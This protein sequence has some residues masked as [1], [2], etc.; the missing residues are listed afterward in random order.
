MI[1]LETVAYD[2]WE[3]CYRIANE[4]IELLVPL[5]IGIRIIHFGFVGEG[6]LFKTYP[7]YN[8]KAGGDDWLIYG[9][10]RLWLAPEDP[11]R[12]Y[13]PDNN[14]ITVENHDNF[15]R[16]IQPIETQTGIQKEIDIYMSDNSPHVKLVH[17]LRNMNLWAVEV[18]PWAL[19]V[20]NSNGTAIAPLPQR[21][22]HS[23]MMI[24]TSSL[25][26]W[27]YTNMSDSRWIWG[28][29]YILLVQNP[30]GETPQKSGLHS[31]DGWLAYA[32]EHG[33]FVKTYQYHTGK[34]YPD[35]NSTVELFTNPDMLELETLAP[36][37]FI[38]PNGFAEHQEDWYL[39][40]AVKRPTNDQEV[41]QQILPSIKAI[42]AQ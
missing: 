18:A 20:M 15:V 1:K 34:T 2:G 39:F 30:N 11:I 24:P 37:D 27:G 41:E 3:K 17:R 9:G 31:P 16:L 35:L 22:S 13:I 23:E 38:P 4:H 21:I 28:E 10:H 36:L 5:E 40:P 25:T 7:E 12:T 42:N 29:R 26:L 6:N 14:P 19:S 33:L 8:G 32:H